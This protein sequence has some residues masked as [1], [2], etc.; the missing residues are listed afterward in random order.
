MTWSSFTIVVT[1]CYALYYGGNILYDLVRPASVAKDGEQTEVLR[2]TEETAPVIVKGPEN[3]DEP[4]TPGRTEKIFPEE[5][6]ES[7]ETSPQKGI[8]PDPL[9]GGLSIS[10][11][12][13]A[14]RQKAVVMTTKHDFERSNYGVS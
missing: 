10:R 6:T 12:L 7:G 13:P 11:L 9:S 14:I 2:F 8:H 4:V 1:V 5:T 3:D